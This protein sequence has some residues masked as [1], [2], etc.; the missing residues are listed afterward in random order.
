MYSAFFATLPLLD[1]GFNRYVPEGFLTSCSF[2]YLSE[3]PGSRILIVVFFFA[4]WIVPVSIIITSYTAIYRIIL[5]THRKNTFKERHCRKI[6]ARNTEMKAAVI[7][8]A[9]ICLWVFAWTP[10]AVVALLGVTGN[11][12]YITPLSSMIPAL[13][14]KLASCLD[15]YVYAI[16]NSRFRKELKIVVSARG[17]HT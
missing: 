6:D 3:D 4:A 10:Y 14:C 13:F 2:D 5:K 1:I 12:K 17:N 16:S 15:P 11:R 7:I 9:I 8:I